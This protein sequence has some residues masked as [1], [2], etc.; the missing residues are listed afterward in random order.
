MNGMLGMIKTLARLIRTHA[1][2]TFLI[3]S[4]IGVVAGLANTATIAL[5]HRTIVAGVRPRLILFGVFLGLCLLA[6]GTRVLS[7]YLLWKGCLRSTL[8]LVMDLTA[9]VLSSPLRRLEEI[10]PSRILTALERDIISLTDA[11]ITVPILLLNCTVLLGCTGYLVYLRPLAALLFI[12]LILIATSSTLFIFSRTR[13]I[14]QQAR[15]TIDQLF[16]YYRAQL[17]GIKELQLNVDRRSDFRQGLKDTA[18]SASRLELLVQTIYVAYTGWFQL[19]FLVPIGGLVFLVTN[20]SNTSVAEVG[21]YALVLLYMTSPINALSEQIQ[22][23]GRGSIAFSNIESLGLDLARTELKA[24]DEAGDQAKP[25][26]QLTLEGL[27]HTFAGAD[28]QAP[29]TVGPLNLQF[30][31]GQLVFITGGNGS[32]KTTLGKLLC[33]L[34]LPDQGCIKVD[35]VRVAPRLVDAYRRN[36]SAIFSDFYLFKRLFGLSRPETEAAG[37]LQLRELHLDSKLDIRNGEFTTVDL[38]QGQRKRLALLVGRLEKRDIYVFDE[39][40]ADQDQMFREYFYNNILASLR[41]E[42]KTIFVISHD[43]RYFHV[44]DRVIKLEFGQV[45]SD[46]RMREYA[47]A[48]N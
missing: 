25:W 26:Y 33:G 9:R 31:R 2:K 5:I 41:S 38:S 8:T 23:L 16:E 40:A 18:V 29:F 32:G 6:Q 22:T 47:S 13:G 30:G 46:T 15:K 44:A 43:E 20:F 3:S 7:Q 45:V 12:A 17:L 19:L 21:A 14:Q 39:W 27:T 36:F 37:R 48:V 10:G 11:V 34:Y 42:G 24:A 35:D 4:A 28:G 1:P